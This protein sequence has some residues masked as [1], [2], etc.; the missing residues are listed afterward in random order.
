[1]QG[2]NYFHL[3]R[4]YSDNE[5]RMQKR[6]EFLSE[7]TEDEVE[8]EGREINENQKKEEDIEIQKMNTK[9]EEEENEDE[10]EDTQIGECAICRAIINETNLADSAGDSEQNSESYLLCLHCAQKFCIRSS[11]F[12]LLFA[13]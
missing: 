8:D 2:L 11:E 5:N 12:I 4:K 3:E 6:K 10:R 1:L 9:A 7:A 13:D